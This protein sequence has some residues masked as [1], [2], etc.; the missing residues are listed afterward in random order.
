MKRLIDHESAQSASVEH[1]QPSSTELHAVLLHDEATQF[2]PTVPHGSWEWGCGGFQGCHG[3]AGCGSSVLGR[4]VFMTWVM[5]CP[6]H[7]VETPRPPT[8]LAGTTQRD[9]LRLGV[10]YWGRGRPRN[11]CPGNAIVPVCTG[12]HG[13]E[14]EGARRARRP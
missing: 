14:G 2:P 12:A 1:E 5:T 11:A 7:T 4:R 6:T 9:L 8:H 13:A 10:R 3:V